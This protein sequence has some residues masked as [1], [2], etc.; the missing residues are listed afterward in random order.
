MNS[1]SAFRK[2]GA[3]RKL[4]R[5]VGVSTRERFPRRSPALQLAVWGSR[6]LEACGPTA[7]TFSNLADGTIV[8]VSGNDLTLTVVPWRVGRASSVCV[9]C[10]R[11]AERSRCHQL[12]LA[13]T[14][15]RLD[16][17]S[18]YRHGSRRERVCWSADYADFRRFLE[19]PRMDAATIL[20]PFICE[21]LRNLR[22]T[23]KTRLYSCAAG[24]EART[25]SIAS[26]KSSTPD[27]GTMI[28]FR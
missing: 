15:L 24:S 9:L 7:A 21:N 16:G 11:Q 1:A 23:G 6:K 17:V 28:T 2:S 20:H 19:R 12:K 26:A 18:P 10:G 4:E 5:E 22:T 3:K 13:P 27:I 14:A 25:S 8:N